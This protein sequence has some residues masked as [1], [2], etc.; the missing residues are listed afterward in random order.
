MD[1]IVEVM[2]VM[3]KSVALGTVVHNNT[4]R[5][6]RRRMRCGEYGQDGD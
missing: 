3:V 6:L 4:W 1:T 5:G 2:V